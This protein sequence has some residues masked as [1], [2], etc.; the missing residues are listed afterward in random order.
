MI[1]F[2]FDD[3]QDLLRQQVRRFVEAE[4][5]PIRRK[6]D[7]EGKFPRDLFRKMGQLGFFTLRYPEE[8]GGSDA[9]AISF[10]VLLEELA[11]GDL[12]LAAACQM[13]SLMGTDLVYRFGTRDHRER[14]LKPALR[15]EKI[16]TICMTEPN[17]GSDLGAIETKAVKKGDRWVLNGP[18]TWIT[19]GPDADF[20][21]VAAKSKPEAG[22]K[23][24]DLFL[25]E[26]GTPGL[27]LGKPIP[28]LGLRASSTAELSFEDCAIPAE[29]LMG[30]VGTGFANLSKILNE[31]RVQTGA[32]SLGVARAAY[33]DALR[34]SG[35]RIAFGQ[36]IRKF[37]A[38]SS[39]LADMATLIE[40]ASLH[41]YRSSW[42]IEQGKPCTKEAAMAKL[43]AS[44]AANEVSDLAM[45]I[46]AAYGFS[47]EY[48]VQR[49]FRDAR[50]LLLGGGTS[51]I[52][53]N[54]I[55]R[56]L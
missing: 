31:I 6:L 16:G 40:S 37:Q 50:F 47:M 32:L 33:E 34:Y 38:I 42:L 53:R 2:A 26:R 11:R 36:P 15:G 17:A 29:N 7:E 22:F 28:K 13:Q 49:Y 52:L 14:L 35:E 24:I 45:R 23:G 9:G 39:K 10:S 18:K 3:E 30:E 25:V 44:E 43:I 20:Y 51:E 27:Q 55:N 19:L 48:D 5:L 12:S 4:V 21:T 1:S 46:F 54:I 56:E 8:V 41:V